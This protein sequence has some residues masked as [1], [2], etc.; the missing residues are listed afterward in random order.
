MLC[1]GEHP[2]MHN[3]HSF[4]GTPLKKWKAKQAL[5]DASKCNTP[6]RDNNEKYYGIQHG[7]KK[8]FET[9]VNISATYLWFQDD[10]KSQ[11]AKTWFDMGIFPFDGRATTYGYFVDK[12]PHY[13]MFH[14]GASKAMLT[15]KFYDKHPIFHHYPKYPINVQPIQV[16]NNHFMTVK[17]AI[18]FYLFWR[19]YI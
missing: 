6:C 11:S 4:T 12:T 17:E 2:N 19:P 14:T 7:L 13:T 1:Y 16:A 8:E 9:D 18:F 15:K 3:L 5:Q 10:A